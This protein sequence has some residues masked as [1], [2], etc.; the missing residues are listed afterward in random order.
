MLIQLGFEPVFSSTLQLI[1]VSRV[2][3]SSPVN[4]AVLNALNFDEILIFKRSK[5]HIFPLTEYVPA[6]FG[7]EKNHYASENV[8][9][10]GCMIEIQQRMTGS[11]LSLTNL[12]NQ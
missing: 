6:K 2:T 5:T 10:C 3:V 9:I 12:R 11:Q 4:I 7:S 1:F 8:S